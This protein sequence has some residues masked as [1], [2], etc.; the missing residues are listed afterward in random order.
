MAWFAKDPLR[1]VGALVFVPYWST[2]FTWID[3]LAN[4]FIFFHM[5]RRLGRAYIAEKFHLK[6]TTLDNLGRKGAPG[7]FSSSE[8]C[9][10]PHSDFRI[11]EM[12]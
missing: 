2:L 10:L 7:K 4:D 9:L 5:S 6:E 12:T 8:A 11:S 1:I 3:E